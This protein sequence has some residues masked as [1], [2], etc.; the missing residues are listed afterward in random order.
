M[1]V[2]KTMR[3]SALA[4]LRRDREHLLL[5]FFLYRP[6]APLQS[7]LCSN[8]HN[9]QYVESCPWSTACKPVCLPITVECGPTAVMLGPTAVM[10]GP[11][12][13]C[14]TLAVRTPLLRLPGD[15][16]YDLDETGG[17]Q[18]CY[19]CVMQAGVMH[20]HLPTNLDCIALDAI[21]PTRSV[22]A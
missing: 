6:V 17:Q 8:V 16:I 3:L 14:H 12:L 11:H 5:Y 1:C 15:L 19:P 22:P 13:S 18:W 4:A 7:L 21:I 10:L 9:V 20:S 2:Y